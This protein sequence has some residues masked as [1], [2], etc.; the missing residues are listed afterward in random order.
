MDQKTLSILEFNKVREQLAAHAA[1]GLGRERALSLE[2]AVEL[3]IIEA[4]Q[5][6]TAEA[7][8]SINR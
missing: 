6:E 4:R 7:V 1:F 3:E 2:P 5:R 8:E